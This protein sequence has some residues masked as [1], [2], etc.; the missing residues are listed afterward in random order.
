MKQTTKK[1][2]TEQA[3]E[4]INT[5]IKLSQD[6][7]R[8]ALDSAV[9]TEHVAE[10]YLQGLYKLGYDTQL[11]GINVS[12]GYWDGL[13]RIRK[14]WVKLFAETGEKL[15]TASSDI[16]LPFKDEAVKFGK[17]IYADTQKV[18]ENFTAPLKE[19]AAK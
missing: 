9:Q 5:V 2:T 4:G 11:A 17:K 10:T 12:K 15:I 7:A 8:V 3:V 14:E 1:E 16:E 13:A 18:V 19:A 6:T